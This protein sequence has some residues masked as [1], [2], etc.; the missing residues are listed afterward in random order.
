MT[1]VSKRIEL[2]NLSKHYRDADHS[3]AVLDNVSFA[4]PEHG[5]VAIMGRS[6]IGKSTLMHLI[7]ALDTPTSGSVFYGEKEVS[8]LDTD[9]RAAFRSLHVGFIFQFHHL[10]SEFSALENVAMPLIMMG[11]PEEG[12]FTESAA[13]LSRMGL[14]QRERHLPSQLSGGE[15]QRVAIAR[16]LVTR[17]QVVLADEPTGNLDFT[18]GAQVQQL[19]LEVVREQRTTLIVVTHNQELASSMDMTVEMLPG[20]SLVPLAR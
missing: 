7:G 9:A 5:S 3:L 8:A 17:P 1:N 16:A 4:F 10:F 11:Q 13:L 12:A 19:L 6:G 15:Q 14:S 20:G 2:R 18:T